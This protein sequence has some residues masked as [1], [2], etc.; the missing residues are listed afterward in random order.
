MKPF[1]ETIAELLASGYT[2]ANVEE[3]LA[4][5]IMLKALSECGLKAQVTVKGGVVMATLTR[6]IRRTTMDLGIDLIRHS[7]RTSQ[8]TR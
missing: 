1:V 7:C 2:E 4:Q 5:D 6:D 3:K 8:S